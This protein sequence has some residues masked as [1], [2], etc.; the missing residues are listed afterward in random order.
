[1]LAVNTAWLASATTQLIA[2]RWDDVASAGKPGE[3]ALVGPPADPLGRALP[4]A[5]AAVRH[6]FGAQETLAPV[7]SR[8]FESGGVFT[9]QFFSPSGD[10]HTLTDAVVAVV[11]TALRARFASI[12][13]T[14]VRVAEIGADGP[15]FNTNVDA[16][17]RYHERE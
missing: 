2:I 12:H 10:G 8:R 13:F 4:W 15:W 16:D 9:L 5:R 11:K 6:T 3:D 17:F 1:M 7:G 14:N